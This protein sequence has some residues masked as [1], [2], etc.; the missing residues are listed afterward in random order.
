VIADLQKRM[1]AIEAQ[2]K[3]LTHTSIR[4][5]NP[6]NYT[7]RMDNIELTLERQIKALEK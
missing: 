1:A 2:P 7:Q 6:P 3:L 5:Q 4:E